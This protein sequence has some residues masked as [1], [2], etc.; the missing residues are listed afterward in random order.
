MS[1]AWIYLLII[2]AL[3]FLFYHLLNPKFRWVVLL[4]SSIIFLLTAG[5]FIAFLLTIFSVFISYEAAIL[6]DKTSDN[7]RQKCILASAVIL[8]AAEFVLFKFNGVNNHFVSFLSDF[9]HLNTNIIKNLIIPLGFSY[10]SLILIAYMTDVYRK[11]A[12]VQKN[13][14]KY[15]LFSLYF[16]QILMGPIVRYNEMKE[17]LFSVREI[18]FDCIKF[19]I[20]RILW[21]LMKKL[22]I[23]DRLAVVT[24]GILNNYTEYSGLNIAA[25]IVLFGIQFYIDFSSA[26]D[27]VLGISECFGIKMPE[28]FKNPLFSVSFHDYWKRWHITLNMF[29]RDYIFYPVIRSEFVSKI[30]NS[31]KK[32]SLIWHSQFIPF[33]IGYIAVWIVAGCWHGLQM[34]FVIANCMLPCIFLILEDI[35]KPV[36]GK[37][38]KVKHQSKWNILLRPIKML[39][40]FSFLCVC[41]CFF[42]TETIQEG[43]QL[44]QRV[45]FNFNTDTKHIGQ[46]IDVYDALVLYFGIVAIII[47]DILKEIKIDLKTK[48]INL[49]LMT[50]WTI[51]AVLMFII[52]L[53][54]LYGPEFNP[55]DFIYFK[56]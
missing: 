24:G 20:F 3:I 34:K 35:F 43:F 31:F 45:L 40:V 53:L 52:Q 26:M 23:A 37:I 11:V 22:V 5:G 16:P 10:Y 49:P 17:Q 50:R 19:G 21:G 36:F 38:I 9:F 12:E 7:K 42:N 30:K 28:N 44:I 29:F 46:I 56:L 6:I 32:R 47:V 39:Y 51:I 4:I 54:G 1:A 8:L 15:S 27:I 55:Q 18:N 13:F 25:A 33:F 41:W 2:F 14:F 48:Y